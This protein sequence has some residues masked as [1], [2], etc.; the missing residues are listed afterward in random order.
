MKTQREIEQMKE[1]IQGR[2]EKTG[3]ICNSLD[4]ASVEWYESDRAYAKLIAQ[5]NILIEVLK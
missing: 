4:H 5:Y 1:E 2:T 3:A